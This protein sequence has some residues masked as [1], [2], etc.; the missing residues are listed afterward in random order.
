MTTFHEHLEEEEA[1]HALPPGYSLYQ[2][3]VALV[4][5]NRDKMSPESII[6][7]L[8]IADPQGHVDVLV[9]A[10]LLERVGAESDV[11]VGGRAAYQVVVP[12]PP[13]EHEWRVTGMVPGYPL[14]GSEVRVACFGCDLVRSVANHLPIEVPE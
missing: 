3:L 13:H 14:A 11:L 7:N 5:P 6:A 9:A 1:L 4:D 10:G 8:V 12:E 2:H